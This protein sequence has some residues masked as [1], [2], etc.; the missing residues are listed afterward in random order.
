[1]AARFHHLFAVAFFFFAGHVSVRGEVGEELK[2]EILRAWD[3][4]QQRT[5]SVRVEWAIEFHAAK[6]N[7]PLRLKRKDVMRYAFNQTSGMYSSQTEY[8]DENMTVSE[9]DDS[10][11]I[12]NERYVAS[13]GK[14]KA[15]DSWLLKDLKQTPKDETELQA[16]RFHAAH[17]WLTCGNVWLPDW[18]R[19]GSFVITR[20][21]SRSDH[22]EAGRLRIHFATDVSRRRLPGAPDHIPSG[23]IDFDPA[24]SYRVLGYEY[25]RKSKVS[26]GLERGVFGYDVGDDL[27]VLKSR[28]VEREMRNVKFG[29]LNGKEIETFAIQ[30]NLDVPDDEFRLSYYGL[31]EPVGVTWKKPTPLYWWLLLGAGVCAALAVGFR[32]LARRRR[33]VPS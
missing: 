10:L 26:E 29:L 15:P 4:L 8:Y 6:D 23:F 24:R 14:A 25:C 31:P 12:H 30:P 7:Q 21:E 18:L 22:G 16:F 19:D 3:R 20:T 2:N 11:E 9:R 33:A 28:T 27:P 1:M 32:Y 5:Q 13:L 17:P